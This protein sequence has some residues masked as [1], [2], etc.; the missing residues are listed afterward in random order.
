MN[1]S[2]NINMLTLMLMYWMW[3][4]VLTHKAISV[5]EYSCARTF[6][7]AYSFRFV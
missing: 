7:P 2:G 6:I 5:A 1:I 3:M 4:S